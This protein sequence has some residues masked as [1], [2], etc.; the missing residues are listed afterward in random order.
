MSYTDVA[1]TKMFTEIRLVSQF[2]ANWEEI[3]LDIYSMFV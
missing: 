3:P 1:V 2:G